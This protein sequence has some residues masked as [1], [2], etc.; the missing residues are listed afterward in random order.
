MTPW[1]GEGVPAWRCHT[2]RRADG[3]TEVEARLAKVCAHNEAL[4]TAQEQSQRTIDS[5]TSQNAALARQLE[6]AQT[7]VHTPQTKPGDRETL[8]YVR[9]YLDCMPA[10]EFADLPAWVRS[11]TQAWHAR[12]VPWIAVVQTVQR[13]GNGPGVAPAALEKKAHV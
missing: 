2:P 10:G 7:P 4:V 1:W 11:L 3:C 6:A 9:R 8:A 5:L 12:G 13:S